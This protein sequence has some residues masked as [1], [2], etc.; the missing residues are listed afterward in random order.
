MASADIE[1][2]D[3]KV[4]GR[5]PLARVMPA[6]EAKEVPRKQGRPCTLWSHQREPTSSQAN[7][8]RPM[9]AFLRHVP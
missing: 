3:N 1:K 2:L 6:K 4:R 8:S 5:S 9:L 7:S